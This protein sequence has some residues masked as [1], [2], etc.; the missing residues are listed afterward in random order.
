MVLKILWSGQRRRSR[1]PTSPHLIL[2]YRL[3]MIA[4][5]SNISCTF[6]LSGYCVSTVIRC[7]ALT[8]T[9]VLDRTETYTHYSRRV[10]APQSL[11]FGCSKVLV[12]HFWVSC[13]YYNL[14][15]TTKLWRGA[16]SRFHPTSSPSHVIILVDWATRFLVEYTSAYFHRERSA[17]VVFMC[18]RHDTSSSIEYG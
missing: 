16:I 7:I 14:Y 13:W 15:G 17:R 12:I 1:Y 4:F 9:Q 5:D 6:F 18:E 2:G 11:V 3:Y 10:Q 8:S